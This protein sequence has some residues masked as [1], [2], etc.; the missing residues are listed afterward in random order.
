MPQSLHNS[1]VLSRDKPVDPKR[2]RAPNVD[3]PPE[4]ATAAATP[5]RRTLAMLSVAS[6]ASMASMRS[7]DSVLP[8]IAADF[9]TTTA[10]AAGVISAFALG[11]GLL[12]LVYGVLGDRYGKSRVITMATA[13]CAV[14]ALAA[15]LSPSLPWLRT[16]RFVSGATAAGIVPLTMAWIGDKVP[17]AR[18]QEVLGQ[19]LSA[20]V[21]GMIAGQ[22][23]GGVVADTLGWRAGFVLLAVL[24]ALAALLLGVEQRRRPAAA[25]GV[26]SLG[27]LVPFGRI[28]K[29][30]WSRRVL[31][32]TFAEGALTFGALAFIPVYLHAR[33][34]LSMAAAGGVLAL[35]GLGGLA[36]SRAARQLVRRLGERKLAAV[37]GTSLAIAFAVLALA[38][39]WQWTMGA[40]ALAGFGFYAFHSTLQTHA[41]QMAPTARGAAVSLFACFLFT[42]QSIGVVAGA[43]T[44]DRFAAVSLFACAAAALLVLTWT[45]V[46]LLRGHDV[47]VAP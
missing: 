45:F 40:C 29:T 46:W 5:I 19:F 4:S 34:G 11:Y 8:A 7:T 18:R 21:G 24:F 17:Y 39:H 9:T 28:L 16:A 22:W 3:R 1:E 31:G 20:T 42:G 35:Y 13:A 23:L 15:A 25:T 38:P 6:F 2:Q 14:T 41:T 32:V 36:Y 30:P 10:S 26:S 37:G 47:H 27:V 33:F 43:W 44:V 12:Q